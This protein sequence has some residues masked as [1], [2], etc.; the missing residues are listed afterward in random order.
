MA[1]V[2]PTITLEG[3]TAIITG[4]ARGLGLTI[5][6]QLA[7]AGAKVAL[8]DLNADLVQEAAEGLEARGLA[9]LAIVADV[10]DGQSVKAAIEAVVAAWGRIDILVNNAGI[11]PLTPAEE[12]T[13]AEWDRV[14]AVNLKG[15]FL[16]AQA[17]MPVMRA[18]HAGKIINMTSSAAQTGGLIAGMHYSASKAGIIGLTRSLARLLAPE[19]Q[20]NAVAPGMIDTPMTHDWS[21]GTKDNA[22]HQMPMRRMGE[23][24]DV[25]WAVL[26]LASDAADFVVGH[27]LAVSGG[28][29]MG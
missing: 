16:F 9:A 22:L 2:T 26:Y 23:P 15:T 19:I 25:A 6:E 27:T 12:I 3:K 18:Q 5:A 8:V 10:S 4:G 11:C 1:N 7:C 17:V 21:E 14:L 28:L 24:G 13:E 29:Y 20:V